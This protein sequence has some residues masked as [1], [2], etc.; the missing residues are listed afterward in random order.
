MTNF[1][2]KLL[3]GARLASGLPMAVVAEGV[4]KEQYQ[5]ANEL[6]EQLVEEKKKSAKFQEQIRNLEKQNTELSQ[7]LP[8]VDQFRQIKIER[9]TLEQKRQQLE[10]TNSVLQDELNRLRKLEPVIADLRQTTDRQAHS[11]KAM[12]DWTKNLQSQA[13]IV[14]EI[15]SQKLRKDNVVRVEIDGLKELLEQA[16]Q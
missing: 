14:F 1:E 4:A 13:V 12:T 11:C 16:P 2:W 7:R 9:A 15:A 10:K 6:A 3:F 8:Q 5:R